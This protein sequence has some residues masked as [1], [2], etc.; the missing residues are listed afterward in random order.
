[1]TTSSDS[2]SESSNMNTKAHRCP[3]CN[4]EMVQG[5]IFDR[6]TEA[7][8]VL[9]TG[10]R[11][12]RKSISGLLR[13]CQKKSVFRWV[14]SAVRSVVSWSRMRIP[15]LLPNKTLIFVPNYSHAKSSAVCITA[16]T[17]TGINLLQKIKRQQYRHG[18]RKMESR[19]CPTA[20]S[21]LRPN[22]LPDLLY[23]H[24]RLL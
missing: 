16:Y 3:K 5:F 1:M 14:P 2:F 21:R 10:W 17:H 9:S 4:N 8:A 19:F 18:N 7:Y 11:E 6:K 22:C 20:A 23:T 24:C 12:R 13:K 15:N